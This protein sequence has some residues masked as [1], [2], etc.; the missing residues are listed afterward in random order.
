MSYFS[1]MSIGESFVPKVDTSYPTPRQQLIWRVEDVAWAYIEFGGEPEEI[2]AIIK[3]LYEETASEDS[4][5][6]RL[7]VETMNLL[8]SQIQDKLERAIRHAIDVPICTARSE[9]F[10]HRK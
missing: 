3:S 10:P 8:I 1:D 6:E 4:C 7:S 2:N 5:P 9:G